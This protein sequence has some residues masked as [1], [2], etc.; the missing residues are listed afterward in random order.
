MDVYFAKAVG[1]PSKQP[2]NISYPPIAR[3]IPE[4]R[5]HK[6]PGKKIFG[7]CF[8]KAKT[9]RNK[10]NLTL[11]SRGSLIMPLKKSLEILHQRT[12]EG[13]TVEK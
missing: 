7:A 6:H 5:A 9:Y 3:T 2:R 4:F 10:R 11:S 8:S 1:K 12:E 13:V